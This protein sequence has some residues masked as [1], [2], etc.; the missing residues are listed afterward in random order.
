[1]SGDGSLTVP[2][3]PRT[4]TAREA[5][6]V[7]EKNSQSETK[8]RQDITGYAPNMQCTATY[9]TSV[10]T[11]LNDGKTN[12]SVWSSKGFGA[13]IMTGA[14]RDDFKIFSYL[15]FG[16]MGWSI[17]FE[18]PPYGVNDF[19]LSSNRHS[20]PDHMASF[21]AAIDVVLTAFQANDC[22]SGKK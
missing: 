4:I 17:T 19:Y 5:A 14:G 6:R 18:G 10:Y 20:K 1:M 16:E 12:V 2:V 9:G 7:V 3:Q 21:N 15:S 13:R 22:L 11:S 8:T